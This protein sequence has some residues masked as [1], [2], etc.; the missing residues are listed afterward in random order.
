MSIRTSSPDKLDRSSN[1]SRFTL[2]IFQILLLVSVAV[3]LLHPRAFGAA[4]YLLV[5]SGLAVVFQ[6]FR[7]LEFGTAKIWILA[8]GPLLLASLAS[9]ITHD[10]PL[11]R[12]E[13][14]E[15]FFGGLVLTLA[16]SCFSI[17]KED[18]YKAMGAAVIIG[19]GYTTYQTLAF[20]IDRYGEAFHPINF[21]ISA[22]LISVFFVYAMLERSSPNRVEKLLVFAGALGSAFL[23]YL[24]QSRGPLISLVLVSVLLFML[25]AL[26]SDKDLR[27]RNLSKLF[28]IFIAVILILTG[29]IVFDRT[30]EDLASDFSSIGLRW[31]MWIEAGKGISANPL[32]GIGADQA[33]RFYQDSGYRLSYFN[34]AHNTLINV[35]L[36][37]GVFGG[38]FWIWMFIVFPL[39]LLRAQR[40]RIGKILT[41]SLCIFLF[42]FLNSLTQDL[43]SHSFTR[44]LM[45]LCFA[46]SIGFSGLGLIK[47]ETHSGAIP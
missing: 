2:K 42:F 27:F 43:L 34:H 23:V 24:S 26:S 44:K 31:E 29:Y 15:F 9:V 22:G 33:G 4:W 25:S 39:Y 16:F 8:V 47:R 38:I 18:L 19:F 46:L 7:F 11:S 5:L 1:I 40:E 17:N 6:N 41:L 45:A 37:L 13:P 12:A 10:L 30:S 3:L 36:E 35:T 14:I 32:V 28:W 21:G 20:E